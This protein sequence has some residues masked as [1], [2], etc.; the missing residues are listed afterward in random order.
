VA[1]GCREAQLPHVVERRQ[2]ERPMP[3]RSPPPGVLLLPAGKPTPA[4]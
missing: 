2:A 3:S 1:A 4:S